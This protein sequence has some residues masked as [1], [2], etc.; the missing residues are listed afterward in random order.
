MIAYKSIIKSRELRLKLIDRLAFIPDRPYLKMVYWI[1]T[2]RKLNLKNPV[3]FT[4][5]LNWL[6]VNDI[7]P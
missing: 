2:G 7:H 4:E 6:K 3:G 1:K 5:K